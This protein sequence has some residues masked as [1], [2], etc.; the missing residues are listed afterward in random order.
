MLTNQLRVSVLASAAL[1]ASLLL[2]GCGNGKFSTSTGCGANCPT[3]AEFLYAF[4][5]FSDCSLLAF[6]VDLSTGA[7]G[8]PAKISGPT[9]SW[10]VVATP[11]G[12]YLY[13]SD[14]DA[15]TI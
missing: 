6:P 4:G 9:G 8:S 14:S 1:V 5:C 7:L 12:K 10:G 13:V 11:S 3:T 15:G 2:A